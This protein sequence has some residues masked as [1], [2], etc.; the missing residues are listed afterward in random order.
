MT[1][2]ELHP[3]LTHYIAWLKSHEK[4]LIVVL[5]AWL[6][7][8]VYGKGIDAWIEHDKRVSTIA[9]QQVKVDDTANQQ[10]TQQVADLKQQLATLSAQAQ[11]KQAERIVVVQQQKDKIQ[12]AAPSELA[13]SLSALLSV[14]QTDVTATQDG[15][16]QL[17]QSAAKT[18]VNDLIDGNA[19]KE[20]LFDTQSE[21][22]A[23]T[24]VTKKDDDLIAGL[25][26]QLK[27]E[28]ASHVAD[29]NLEKAKAKKAWRNGFKWGAVAGF[30]GGIITLK[31]F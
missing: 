5:S 27:D 12:Q 20:Q 14:P 26:T 3:V 19:A 8:H 22:K 25:N 17:S 6:V 21:L 30:V 29:V 18:D 24:A 9:A 16:I 11:A 7:W 13:T 15:L 1:D 28:K 23:C 2:Q 31:K 10:L 4:I